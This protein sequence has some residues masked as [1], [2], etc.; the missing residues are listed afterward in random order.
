MEKDYETLD[1]LKHPVIASFM[2][3]KWEQIRRFYNTYLRFYFMFIY[4]L[5]WYIFEEFGGK[6]QNYNIFVAGEDRR[7]LYI[8]NVFY[9]FFALIMFTAII[10]N[11]I[12]TIYNCV[13]QGRQIWVWRGIIA[14][15][16][17]NCL[18]NWTSNVV[19]IT[20]FRS[21]RSICLQLCS[22]HWKCN[23]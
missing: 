6:E 1:L 3:L 14:V 8:F 12:E 20:S 5:T 2:W 7:H 11:C 15:M 18:N 16:W 21:N 13:K 19:T 23:I 9:Y 17:F 22:N 10:K 4:I